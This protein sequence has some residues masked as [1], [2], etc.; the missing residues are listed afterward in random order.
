[1][2]WSH[3]SSYV[4]ALPRRYVIG[5]VAVLLLGVV[6]VQALRHPGSATDTVTSMT[7]VHTASV[8]SLSMQSTPLLVT[9]KVTSRDQA[10]I[11]AQT[12]GEI[13]SLYRSIG[14]RVLAGDIIA[15]FENSSQEAAV[16]QA[17]GAYD[18]ATAALA[19]AN[20]STAQNSSVTANLATQAVK[21]AQTAGV[22]ALQSAYAALDDAVHTR[23]DLLFT[24]PRT[25]AATLILTVPDN[26]LVSNVQSGRIAL[27]SLLAEAQSVVNDP[28]SID[29]DADSATFVADAQTVNTFLTN[30]IKAVNETQPSQNF[31]AA[32]LAG[33]QTS[34]ATARTEVVAAISSVTAAKSAYDSAVSSAT[35]AANSAGS[36]TANDI[37]VAQANVKQ[38]LGALDAAKATLEKTIIRSPISG[39]IVSLP[40]TKGSYVSS[41][42]QV[43]VVSNPGALYVD[44]YV[45]PDDAK[46]LAVGN[47]VQIDGGV[48]GVITFIAPAIDPATSK[49]EVKVGVTGDQ[50]ALTDGEVVTSALERIANA[51]TVAN[52]PGAGLLIPIEAAKLTPEGPVVFTVSASST[53]VAHAITFGNIIGSQVVVN[54]V[55]GDLVI[56]TDARGLAEG[57]T[58]VVDEN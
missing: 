1:M 58:V 40:I 4:R 2:K 33:Y 19:K 25:S 11:L 7:H 6:G 13:V 26:L 18:A 51:P 3:V 36:G 52:I 42:S 10:T 17:Q 16:L 50:R 57:Q 20:G 23:A 12:S 53:L 43:S 9:G 35:T 32:T 46:T 39:T 28:D 22:A 24:N 5:A 44:A 49:I 31:S 54:G 55:P 14:D 47:K 15:E 27:E 21:N 29:F 56:V 45:T 37:A 38:T 41:F 34:L 30:L 8:A 48:A